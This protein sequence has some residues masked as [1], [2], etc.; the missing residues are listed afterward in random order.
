MPRT[1][2]AELDPATGT[3]LDLAEVYAAHLP[4]VWAS[5]HRL[6]VRAADL[7]DL[8][9]EVFV[10]VHRRRAEY[11]GRPL[12]GWLWGICVGL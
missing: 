2:E 5:L 9:Q 12:R 1:V 8:T 10:V 7:P 6:G 3:E 11:D 4:F